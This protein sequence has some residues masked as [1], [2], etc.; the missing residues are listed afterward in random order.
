[1][2]ARILVGDVR[3]RLRELPDGSAQCCVT[4]PPYWGLRDYGTAQ[5]R[6][7]DPSCAHEPTRGRQGATGQRADRAHTQGMV[8]REVCGRCG[9]LRVDVQ[10]GLEPTPENYVQT[11]VSV[12]REVRRVLADDGVLWLNIGDTYAASGRGGGGGSFQNNAMGREISE[13]NGFRMPPQGYKHKDLVGVPWMLALALRADG[14]YL[15]SDVIWS[16]P[17]PM[18]ESVQ[19]RPTKAHEY[20][21]L[22]SK[23]ERYYYDREAICEP[24]QQATL[25]RG[26]SIRQVSADGHKTYRFNG[27]PLD[28]DSVAR[29][30]NARSVWTIATQ[31]YRGAHFAVMPEALAEPCVLAA[32][33]PGDVVLDPFAGAGTVAVVALRHDREFVG[34]ELNPSYAAM[35]SERIQAEAPLL[36]RVEI[37]PLFTEVSA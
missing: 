31:P 33:R 15:R 34:C 29:G 4:S 1:M 13:V 37:V 8:F 2:T 28:E 23:S 22:L 17:N 12:F 26:K 7:G 6:G 10:I 35:A 21:F 27:E 16:K 5:W 25:K 14:W 20:V 32:S 9:A 30:R 36:N 19:D 18:P 11:M 3:D 24:Y